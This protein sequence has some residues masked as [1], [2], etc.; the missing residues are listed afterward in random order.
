MLNIFENDPTYFLKMDWSHL[1]G[2]MALNN[3]YSPLLSLYY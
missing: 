1:G 2:V 3:Y